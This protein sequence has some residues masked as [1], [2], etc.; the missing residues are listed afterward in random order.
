MPATRSSVE[1]ATEFAI[2]PLQFASAV[3]LGDTLNQLLRS[4][5]PEHADAVRVVADPRTNSLLLS[6]SKEQLAQ[7]RQLVER[8]DARVQPASGSA[9]QQGQ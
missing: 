7:L 2:V 3:E 5:R 8:L 1:V 9:P 6:G 4:N